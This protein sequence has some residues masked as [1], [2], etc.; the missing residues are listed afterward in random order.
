MELTLKKQPVYLSEIIFDG[1]TE[2]GVEFD[3]VLPDY[4]PDIFKILKCTL[5]PCISS[6]SI[7]GSQ[8]FC[9]GVVYIKALYLSADSGGNNNININCIEHRYTFSKTIELVKPA[10]KGLVTL[11]PKSDYCNCRA[12]SSR[13]IDVRGAIS[14]KIKIVQNAENEIIDS[15]EGLGLQTKKSDVLYCGNKLSA[16]QQFVVREDIET[17]SGR[18]GISAVISADA[19]AAVNDC[20][21]I[22]NKVIVK[23]EAKVKALYM[24][25]NDDGSDET[26]VMEASIPLSRIIDIEGIGDDYSLFAI[27]KIM[28]CDLEVK[29]NEAGENRTFG[30]ELTVDCTINACKES[31]VSVLSDVYS[32]NY[33]AAYTPITIKTECSPQLVSEQLNIKV[34]LESTDGAV[35]EIF[36]ARCDISNIVCKANESNALVISGQLCAQAI[37]RLAD[38]NPIFIEKNEPFECVS[39]TQ[40]SGEFSIIPDIQVAD[41]GFSISSDNKVELRIMLAFNACIYR[42][43]SV[44]AIKEISVDTDKPKQKISDYALKLYYAEKGEDIWNIAKHYNTC[45][46]AIVAENDLE[47]DVLTSPAMLLIPII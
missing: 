43:C 7:S 39:N 10:E 2:Q 47:N 5:T 31:S 42:L 3:Y 19:H 21:I 40:A 12:I 18:G 45:A 20:R 11:I 6:Y 32:T 13:R 16:E 1:Q 25:K 15:A 30:C 35:G 28:D 22:A 44:N 23:G 33:D 26:E 36:D 17:G 37:G 34:S 41:T 14:C 29:Q 8:L 24:M 9:D 4:Y 27:L 46:D 38:G